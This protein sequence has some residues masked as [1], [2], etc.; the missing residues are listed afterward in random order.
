MCTRNVYKTHTCVTINRNIASICQHLFL[1]MVIFSFISV[2]FEISFINSRLTYL[3]F[4]YYLSL[5]CKPFIR[6]Y[7]PDLNNH[8][9]YHQRTKNDSSFLAMN[10]FLRKEFNFLFI[11]FL[12]SFYILY[13]FFG[14]LRKNC[15]L[16]QNNEKFLDTVRQLYIPQCQSQSLKS[17]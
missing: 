8:I 16:D 14:L 12:F 10:Y 3:K 9:K 5:V 13:R 17:L 1:S 4:I 15:Q 2:P 11:F 6:K 7:G